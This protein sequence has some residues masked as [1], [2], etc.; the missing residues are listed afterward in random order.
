MHY[1]R[2]IVFALTAGCT[3]SSSSQVLTGQVS[4]NGFPSPITQVRVV[5]SGTVVA[6]SQVAADGSFSL[7]VAPA[8]GLTLEAISSA[9]KSG[10][11]FPRT[12]GT[13]DRT[14]VVHAAGPAFDVGTLHFVGNTSTTTFAFK[15]AA[16]EAECEDG[17]DSTGATC[18]D[19]EDNSHG[20]CA[21]DDG[22]ETQDANGSDDNVADDGDSVAD[23]NFPADGCTEDGSDDGGSDG[24]G[25]DGGSG[26]GSGSGS[27]H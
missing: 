26:S 2:F 24:S 15:T 13:I 19:D 11:V 27:G 18:V 22:N 12:A 23:H 9:G 20:M 4:Q 7:A 3:S 5:R 8:N 25:S 21:S 1:S 10:V 6:T 16:T 14:F 17:H